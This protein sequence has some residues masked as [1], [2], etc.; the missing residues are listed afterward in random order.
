MQVQDID[1]RQEEDIPHNRTEVIEFADKPKMW[2]IYD[3]HDK[4]QYITINCS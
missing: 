1:L 2:I 3:E 4:V